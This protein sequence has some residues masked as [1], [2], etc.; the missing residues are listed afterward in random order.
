[1]SNRLS[2]M[3]LQ[4]LHDLSLTEEPESWAEFDPPFPQQTADALVRRGLIEARNGDEFR[5][6]DA[7]RA[8]LVQG[9][10]A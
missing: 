3:Q 5:L 4:M 7:G 2:E 6:T 9:Y 8:A 10:T 1:M